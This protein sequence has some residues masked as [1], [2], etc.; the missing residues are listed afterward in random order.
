MLG[1]EAVR[2][3][4]KNTH[5]RHMLY[6]THNLLQDLVPAPSPHLQLCFVVALSLS[7]LVTSQCHMKATSLCMKL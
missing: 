2:V 4:E 3:R 5:I 7:R 6:K 1:N